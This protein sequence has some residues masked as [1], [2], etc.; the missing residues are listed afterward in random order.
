MEEALKNFSVTPFVD[1]GVIKLRIT[2]LTETAQAL[3]ALMWNA[4]KS[5][6]GSPKILVF[7]AFEGGKG[8]NAVVI[9]NPKD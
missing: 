3:L 1:E 9:E 2:P 5:G 6:M 7:R 4:N 8:L